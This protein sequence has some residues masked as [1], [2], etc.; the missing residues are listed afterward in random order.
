MKNTLRPSFVARGFTLLEI[1][2]VLL[3]IGLLI[4]VVASGLGGFEESGQIQATGAKIQSVRAQL[5]SFKSLSGQY[6]TTSQGLMA[7]HTKPSGVS[8]WTQ[9]IKNEAD[10][11]D[12]W[13]Q[14]L[15]YRY[16]GSHNPTSFDIWSSGPDRQ[17]GT[18]DD[19]GNW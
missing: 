3:I 19:I 13:G 7:L 8:R 5:I 14:K 17:D 4:G 9:M 6:P 2:V 1:M 11:N 16:P 12:P 15:F 18:D 10:L